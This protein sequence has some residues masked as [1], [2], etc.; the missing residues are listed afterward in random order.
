MNPSRVVVAAAAKHSRSRGRGR[1]GSG[2]GGDC[3]GRRRCRSTCGRSGRGDTYRRRGSDFNLN[4]DS[5][6]LLMPTLLVAIL[7]AAAMQKAAVL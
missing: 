4:S 6:I 1:S 7:V 5:L 2:G 3:G